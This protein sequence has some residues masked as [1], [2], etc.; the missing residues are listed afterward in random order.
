MKVKVCIIDDNKEM[1]ELLT[2]HLNATNNIEVIGAAYNGLEALDLLKNKSP[3]V[4]LLDIILPHLDGLSVLSKL[5]ESKKTDMP[6]VIIVTAFAQDDAIKKALEMGIFYFI[7]K[8]FDLN[9]IATKIRSAKSIDANSPEP[10]PTP[11]LKEP[12][13]ITPK[14][15]ETTKVDLLTRT[16]QLIQEFN[17]PSHIRGYTYVREAIL[18]VYNNINLLNAMTT[19]LYPSIASKFDT[20][21][22]R[23]ERAIRHGIDVSW[24]ESDAEVLNNLFGYKGT[25]QKAKT[26]PSNRRFISLVADKLRLEYNK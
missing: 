5:K 21:P 18:L 11:I 13:A 23:V 20:T 17:I 26:K 6:K 24:R 16:T 9:D 8:P 19:E 3:D 7:A 10:E 25:K 4:V 2:D 22:S 14:S 12:N 1:V 15:G